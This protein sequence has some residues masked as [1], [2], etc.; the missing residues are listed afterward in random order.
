MKKRKEG[1]CATGPERF[2]YV[3]FFAGQLISNALVG[4]FILT[5]LLNLGIGEV[6]AGSI[7][8]LPK[9][10]DAV[11]DTL[12]GFIVDKVKFK[13]GR[14]LPWIRISSVLMPL[15]V[16]FLFSV[17]TGLNA[18]MKCAWVILGYILWDTCYTM[19]DAPIYALSTSMTNNMDERT[20]IL[21]YRGIS[22]A[23]GGLATAIVVPLLYGSNGANLGWM[24][25]AV[26]MG[27]VAAV[28]M[29]PASFVVKERFHGEIEE[30]VGFKELLQ[31]LVKN[32]NLFVII[33]VRFLFLLT[34]TLEV[35]SPVFAFY[36]LGNETMGALITMMISLPML[37][38]AVVTPILCRR[39]DKVHLLVFFMAVFAGGCVVQY[40]AGYANMPVFLVLN[41]LR[42]IG[43][44]GFTG[45]SFMFVPD[46]IEYGQYVTG[47]RNEG[48]AF[49]LQTFV[50]KL[51]SALISTVSAY[52]I[53]AL[54]FNAANVT[55]QGKE[56][57]WF[58]FTIFAALGC[59]AAI[60]LLLKAYTLRD[61]DVACMI[62]CNNGEMSRDECERRMNERK[63]KH[64]GA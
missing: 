16:I 47:H 31:G 12:F 3:L 10:W 50:G 40:F 26:V 55:E 6:M 52:M 43:Y 11:N 54:G 9:V 13:K 45:L 15:A 63:R 37:V 33:I 20:S 35:L 41:A 59:V 58:C 19:S 5:Y 29:L 51:N 7:L 34:F 18:T 22:G 53:A 62:A 27:V 24:K 17:P 25:T 46:C 8:L 39:F 14:F 1:W 56:G 36:V 57:V 4:S 44:G 38:L 48:V 30:E 2:T 23:I 28:C 32:K 60:P 42:S 49:S 61:K 21:S 64:K